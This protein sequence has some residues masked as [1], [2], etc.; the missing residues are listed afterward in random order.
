MS[1]AEQG[2]PVA[3]AAG[4]IAEIWQKSREKRVGPLLVAARR[5]EKLKY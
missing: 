4:R 2:Q 3:P 1:S 5:V